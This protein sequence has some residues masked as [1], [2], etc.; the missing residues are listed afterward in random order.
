MSAED[1]IVQDSLPEEEVDLQALQKVK[2]LLLSLSNTVSAFKIFPSH[3]ESCLRF[4]QDLMNKLKTYFQRHEK[5]ELEIR[6]FSFSFQGQQVYQDEVSSKSLPYFF[7]KDGMRLLII[8]NGV[9]EEEVKDF[10]EIIKTESSKPADESDIVNAMW[11]RDFSNIQYYVPEEFL[12]NKVLEERAESLSKKGLKVDSQELVSKAIDIKVNK[13]RLFS[14]KLELKPE[15]KKAMEFYVDQA[16]PE[17]IEDW[18][19]DFD[20]GK[21]QV[22]KILSEPGTVQKK[23]P[24]EFALNERDLEQLNQM[25]ERN[26]QLSPEEEFLNLMT[27]ILGLDKDVEQLKTNLEILYDFYQEK[28]KAGNFQLNILLNK[29]MKDLRSLLSP[30]ENEKT[31]LLTEFI[32][33]ISDVRDVEEIRKLIAQKAEIDYSALFEYLGQFQDKALN[34]YAEFYEKIEDE[35]FRQKVKELFGIKIQDDPAR[36]SS[37]VDDRKPL[38]TEFIIDMMRQQPARKVLPYFV[39]F[40]NLYNKA[41]KI[42]A[43]EALSSFDDEAA[44]RILLGFLND[45]I[46]EVR[47][48]A[49]TSLKSLGDVA[50]LK[51]LIEETRTTNFRKKNLAEKKALFQF[52]GR[53]RS[54]EA[55]AFLKKI[56]LKKSIMPSTTELRI[57]AVAGL[58]AMGTEEALTLLRRGK[59]FFNRKLRLASIEAAARLE[60][61][62]LK[63]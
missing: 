28:L 58:E 36:I 26:R 15:E 42:K 45:P 18:K 40:T 10:L 2:E 52:L 23:I 7:F 30:E 24:Q 12:E 17:I 60:K 44:S 1:K 61:M 56:L 48:K 33:R 59:K 3:H 22:P 55:M 6:E 13:E 14:G 38:L 34:F 46:E 20:P 16:L 9:G 25:I 11:M 50:R 35:V 47:L 37:L 53:T 51:Q 57:C 63:G 43:I 27:E 54:Q 31:Q 39:N 5:L 21:L 62:G 32:N 4:R 19:H 49:V 41:L 29:K 8:Y